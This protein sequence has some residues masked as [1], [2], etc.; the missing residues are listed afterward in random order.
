MA[1]C[2]DHSEREASAPTRTSSLPGVYAGRF[3]CVN[4]PGISTALWLRSD[5]RYFIRQR[6]LAEEDD[7]EMI[8]YGLGRWNWVEAD[9]TVVLAG[10]GPPRVFTWPDRDTLIMHT[11]SDLEHRL[12]RDPNEPDFTSSIRMD[13]TMRR[14]GGNIRF[15]ECL[16]GLEVPVMEGGDYARFLHQYRSVPTRREGVFVELEGRF[17]WSEDGTPVS[18]TIDRL[19]TVRTDASCGPASG[20]PST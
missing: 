16:T 20:T 19:V 13:G 14:S 17:A 12:A 3:P 5:G 2:G 11:E 7:E 6:Y 4:C 8:A 15:T 1:G 9:R 10:E 18:L